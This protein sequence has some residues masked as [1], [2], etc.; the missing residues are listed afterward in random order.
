MLGS[1]LRDRADP[2]VD[3]DTSGASGAGAER[4]T[5]RKK[6]VSIVDWSLKLVSLILAPLIV[7][8]LQGAW[9]KFNEV[10]DR[11]TK[12]EAAVSIQIPGLQQQD[13]Y[14]DHRLTRLE[15]WVFGR[16]R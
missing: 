2:L 16:D 8:L 1:R 4:M 13:Q 12:I 11:L 10:G 9:S 3:A 7:Y 15:G 6:F 14:L 5:S